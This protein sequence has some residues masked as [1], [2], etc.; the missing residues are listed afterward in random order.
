M[1]SLKRICSV[2]IIIFGSIDYSESFITSDSR[3][4]S[5]GPAFSSV[6]PSPLNP[7]PNEIIAR[8]IIVNG[9]V[10]GGYYRACVKNEVDI[11]QLVLFQL[12][13]Q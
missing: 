12:C 2:L 3:V 10:Q 7:D 11:L 13:K 9:A 8:R 5:T 6:D 4:T 1:P